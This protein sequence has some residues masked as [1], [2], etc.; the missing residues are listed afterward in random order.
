ML[1]KQGRLFS[2]RFN[3][4]A[5]AGHETNI[6]GKKIV[7]H[8]IP[9]AVVK[10]GATAFMLRGMVVHPEDAL[11]EID[12]IKKSLGVD[13][14]PGNLIIDRNTPLALDTHRAY[15]TV[16]NEA[17]SEGRGST[18]RGIAPAYMDFYGRIS[19]KVRDLTREDWEKGIRKHYQLYQK[20]VGGFGRELQ[21]I[22]VYAM[23]EEEKRR[24][25]TEEEFIDRLREART[26][27]KR[28]V[29]SNVF[30][31]LNDAWGNN[32]KAPFT[33]EGAQGPGTD[34]YHGVYP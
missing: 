24:V 14:L 28:Y 13:R 22:E 4:G 21:D 16:L 27:I 9:M 8:Q 3:G 10:E 1:T 19:K 30:E 12:Y 23:A 11:I 6:Y 31:L 7:T 20:M 17:T 25:G 32:L 15:E 29:A 5:N 33:I 2:L 26:G 34:P 18:G